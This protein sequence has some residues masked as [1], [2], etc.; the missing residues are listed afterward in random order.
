MGVNGCALLTVAAG[1]FGS[2][3][4]RRCSRCFKVTQSAYPRNATIT[5]ALTRRSF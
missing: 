5:W 3:A 4:G 1:G 2:K